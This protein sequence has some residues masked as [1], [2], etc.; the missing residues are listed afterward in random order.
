M[1][2]RTLL[3]VSAGLLANCAPEPEI[4]LPEF[5]EQLTADFEAEDQSES[6]G[7]IWRYEYKGAIVY[8]IPPSP[9]CD[10]LSTLYDESGE[11]LCSPDGGITGDGNGGCAD[12]F[13]SR[14]AEFRVWTDARVSER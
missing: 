4:A 2:S 11:I 3:C 13:E 8:Y 9:C 14:S 6:P 12:F 7:S 1:F 5:L 10:R